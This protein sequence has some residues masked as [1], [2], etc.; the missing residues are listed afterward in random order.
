MRLKSGCG[1]VAAVLVM[2]M[3]PIGAHHSF[4][5]EFDITKTIK[6]SGKVSSVRWS[7]PHAWI[8]MDVANKGKTERWAFEM[9]GA[10][11]LFRRGWRKEDLPAGTVLV[12]QGWLARNGSNTANALYRRGWRKDDLEPGTAVVAEGWLARNGT[13]T[14]NTNTITLPD[15]RRLF[16]GTAP[17]EG[18]APRSP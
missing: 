14:A 7:N 3:A 15:G 10:N 18:T 13:P 2:A 17:N 11:G 5:A 1:I 16:A 12:I 6:V 4:S 9:S 8:Y